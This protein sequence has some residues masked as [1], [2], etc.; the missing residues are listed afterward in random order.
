[1]PVT[2]AKPHREEIRTFHV[3]SR[4]P[5]PIRL[6]RVSPDVMHQPVSSHP[7]MGSAA[8]GAV[9]RL[10]P[11]V[12]IEYH[13]RCV[14]ADVSQRGRTTTFQFLGNI[15]GDTASSLACHKAIPGLKRFK[16]G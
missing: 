5:F 14:L 10:Q 6:S 4:G 11:R 2:M 12:L 13:P 7:L 3:F 1:M 15:C 9:A 16:A 8:A